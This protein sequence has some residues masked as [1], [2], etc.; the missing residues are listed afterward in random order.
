MDEDSASPEQPEGMDRRSLLKRAGLVTGALVWT[1]PVVQ[2][3]AGPAFAGT[4]HEDPPGNGEP[5][6]VFVFVKC[7]SGNNYSIKFE[8]VGETSDYVRTCGAGLGQLSGDA[9]RDSYCLSGFNAQ[10]NKLSGYS[11]ACGDITGA[12]DGTQLV[13]SVPAGCQIVGWFLH[14]GT[15]NGDVTSGNGKCRYPEDPNTTTD[16]VGPQVPTPV[17]ADDVSFLFDQCV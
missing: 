11:S 2:S 14:D 12:G 10:Y 1:T 4:P 8:R 16:P 3:I 6:Y 5:S 7:D 9:A 15:C 13:V 17:V